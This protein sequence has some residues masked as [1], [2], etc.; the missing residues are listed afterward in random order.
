[1]LGL[2]MI[3]DVGPAQ[4]DAKVGV[5]NGKVSVPNGNQVLVSSNTRAT[6]RKTGDGEY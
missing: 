4:V 2:V 6:E 1:M 5:L 3:G